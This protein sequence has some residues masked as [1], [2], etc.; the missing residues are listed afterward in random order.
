MVAKNEKSEI[1]E[2]KGI[3]TQKITVD[4]IGTSPLVCH[5]ISQKAMQEV[6]LPSGKKT[7]AAKE[8]SL[9]HDMLDEFRNSCYQR[10]G[11]DWE[12]RIIFPS[13]GMKGAMM[14]AALELPGLKKTQLGR[15]V[16]V[17]GDYVSVYGIPELYLTAIRTADVNKTLDARTRAII[18]DWCLRI[19]IS[20]VTPTFNEITC[21]RV[22]E[23][24]GI[25][26]GLGDFRQ[27]KGKGSYGQFRIAEEGEIDS[28]IKNGGRKAQDKALANP[29]FYDRES[30]TLFDWYQSER[31]RRG[32]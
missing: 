24:A 26:S 4:I 28:I 21:K 9:K 29:G 15:L 22:I 3:Q 23:A 1:L 31:N 13:A 32:K 30:K 17:H 2:V 7:Q 5:A 20:F 12:T 11:D 27:E 25:I 10:E 6:L 14:N 16:W 18:R 19:D 8:Q